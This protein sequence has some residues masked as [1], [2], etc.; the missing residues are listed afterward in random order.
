MKFGISADHL[1][2]MFNQLDHYAYLMTPIN[3]FKEGLQSQISQN[4]LKII[5]NEPEYKNIV[6]KTQ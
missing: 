3:V 1:R 4:Q 5:E 2:Y 6:K